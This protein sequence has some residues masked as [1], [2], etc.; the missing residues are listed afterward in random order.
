MCGRQETP[1]LG[2]KL[3]WKRKKYNKNAFLFTGQKAFLW[4]SWIKIFDGNVSW[5]RLPPKFPAND[6]NEK[7][8]KWKKFK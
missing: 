4:M 6:P 5:C 3:N 2:L 1:H 8:G 7:K